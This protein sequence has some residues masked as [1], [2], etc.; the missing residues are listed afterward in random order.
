MLGVGVT[1][2]EHLLIIFF[3][4]LS[5]FQFCGDEVSSS[6]FP[7]TEMGLCAYLY[8]ANAAIG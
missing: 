6:H 3:S 8:F 7:F 5:S 4:S 2:I 1:L